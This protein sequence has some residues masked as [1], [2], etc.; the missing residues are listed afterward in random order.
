M[1]KFKGS[2]FATEQSDTFISPVSNFEIFMIGDLSWVLFLDPHWGPNDH[3]WGAH[4]HLSYPR[5]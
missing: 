1:I 5:M 3:L 2:T 4:D